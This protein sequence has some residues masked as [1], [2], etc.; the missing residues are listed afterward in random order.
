V[1]LVYIHTTTD[2][3]VG[4]MCL[5]KSKAFGAK[6]VENMHGDVSVFYTNFPVL[7]E[8]DACREC[9]FASSKS[10]GVFPIHV[11]FEAAAAA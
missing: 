3:S 2:P 11:L 5:Q 6:F 1:P 9:R 10:R 7:L 8:R 4:E